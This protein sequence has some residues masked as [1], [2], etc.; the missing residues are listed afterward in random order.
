MSVPPELAVALVLEPV[1]VYAVFVVPRRRQPF[2]S[3]L[4]ELH[5][6]ERL[7][8]TVQ[9][10]VPRVLQPEAPFRVQRSRPTTEL[11]QLTNQPKPAV[12]SWL[13]TPIAI[14]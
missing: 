6:P 1:L 4:R 9:Q 11:I 7:R 13:H 8:S 14:S 2:H 3:R 12:V 10:R 5:V